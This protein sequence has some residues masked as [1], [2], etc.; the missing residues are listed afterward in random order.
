MSFFASAPAAA[1]AAD[2]TILVARYVA[3]DDTAFTQLLARHQSR[4]F[5]ILFL[6]VHDRTLAEDL[7]QDTFIKVVRILRADRYQEEGKFSAWVG[8]I[9]HNVALDSLRRRKNMATV[10]LDA[11]VNFTD[12]SGATAPLRVAF[13][14]DSTAPSP[15][16]LAIE[17]EGNPY[18]R[19]LIEELPVSQR[20]VLLLRHYGEL[21]FQEIADTMGITVG[22]AL[23]R[24]RNAL[25][26]LRDRML[27]VTSTASASLLLALLLTASGSL[28]PARGIR[29]ES[30]TYSTPE[31]DFDDPTFYPGNAHPVRLQRL[32]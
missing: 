26:F 20:E 32:T 30:F 27:P 16:T 17:T 6:I 3:G 24:M 8:R 23:G 29:G 21:S 1:S 11:P 19:R 25:K 31:S 5:T 9:A 15:E 13:T 2:D 12:C 22:A 14:T 4:V 10:S 7:T 18:L 28:P